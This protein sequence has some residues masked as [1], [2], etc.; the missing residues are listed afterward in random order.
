MDPTDNYS[1]RLSWALLGEI[2]ARRGEFQIADSLFHKVVSFGDGLFKGFFRDESFFR[3]GKYLLAQKR[4]AEAEAQFREIGRILPKSYFYGYGMALLAARRDQ[5][6]EALD[7][8]E[9][10]LDNFWPDAEAVRTEPLFKKI[11]KTKRFKAMMA[12]HFPAE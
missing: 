10:A 12:K 5:P 4:Y 9:R 11:R 7:W 2:H 8:L 6:A 3:Y 1:W